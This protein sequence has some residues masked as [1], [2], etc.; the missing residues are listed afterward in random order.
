MNSVIPAIRLSM[1]RRLTPKRPPGTPIQAGTGVVRDGQLIVELIAV[2]VD[3]GHT[4]LFKGS[5]TYRRQ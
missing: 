1:V 5:D 4:G 3:G 2:K